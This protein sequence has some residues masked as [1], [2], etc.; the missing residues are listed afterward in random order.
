MAIYITAS[1]LAFGSWILA[2]RAI[3]AFNISATVSVTASAAAS[4][5]F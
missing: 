5:L 3:S 1:C 4:A 2:A